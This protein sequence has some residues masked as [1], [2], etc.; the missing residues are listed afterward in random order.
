MQSDSQRSEKTAISGTKQCWANTYIHTEPYRYEIQFMLETLTPI[1]HCV[2]VNGFIYCFRMQTFRSMFFNNKKQNKQTNKK[3][4][5]IFRTACSTIS[6]YFVLYF[7][8]KTAFLV[9]I[10]VKFHKRIHT[11]AH[12]NRKWGLRFTIFI[13]WPSLL[14]PFSFS[15]TRFAGKF[16]IIVYG[17][18]AVLY[19]KKLQPILLNVT[20]MISSISSFILTSAMTCDLTEKTCQVPAM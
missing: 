15:I 12:T 6:I 2:Q 18:A 8:R 4:L 14:L 3:K 16:Y 20:R 10:N 5:Q 13:T 9:A 1:P 7:R 17:F 19:F 11:R